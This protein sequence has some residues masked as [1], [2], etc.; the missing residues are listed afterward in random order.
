[1]PSIT[2]EPAAKKSKTQVK[3]FPRRNYF[4]NKSFQLAFAGNMVLIT[5]I[6]CAITALS[7]SWIFIYFFDEHLCVTLMDGPY[8]LKIG[9]ILAGLIIG[10]ALWTILRTHA[11]AGPIYKTR[12]IL[13]EAAKG[14]FPDRPVVFRRGDAF[15][16][17][18]DDLNLC[19]Q[20]MR[21]DHAR[22]EWLRT[23]A[24]SLGRPSPEEGSE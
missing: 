24:E 20:A 9:F 3:R 11:I 8:L 17:L 4:I 10:V 5:F 16:G 12:K 15:K 13:H 23:H 2:L 22:L 1:M 7:V 14:R 6:A 18:A 19:L 21:S